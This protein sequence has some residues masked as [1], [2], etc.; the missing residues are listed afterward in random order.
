M[1]D[2]KV[3]LSDSGLDNLISVYNVQGFFM[4]RNNYNDLYV[5]TPGKW[6]RIKCHSYEEC[7]K[8]VKLL[9][10]LNYVNEDFV[11]RATSIR[12]EGP[13]PKRAIRIV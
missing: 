4:M 6:M 2:I 1:S 3:S 12:I 10:N 13:D 11:I 8:F 7:I 5:Y 9:S